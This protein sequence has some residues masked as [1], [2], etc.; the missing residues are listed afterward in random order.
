MTVPRLTSIHTV[1]T[2]VPVFGALADELLPGVERADV[3][4]E[5][6]LGEAIAAGHIPPATAA[7][8][9]THVR[10]A[11]DDGADLVLVTCSSMGPVVDALAETHGWPLLRIDEA[12]ADRAIETSRRIGVIATLATTLEPTVDLIRRRA[13]RVGP[14]ADALEIRSVLCEGAF[15]A[16]KAGRLDEHDALVRAGLEQLLPLV[17]VV[18]LA[19]ASMARVAATLDP[20]MTGDRPILASPRLGMERVAERLGSPGERR[21]G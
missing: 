2:L 4:D 11:L 5:A 7:R 14:G 17:D 3:V 15:A 1:G 6:L 13:D 16:L 12:L 8:L 20:A 21:D 18:V 19:Q 10:T 9:E